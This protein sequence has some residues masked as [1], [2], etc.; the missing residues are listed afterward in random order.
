MSQVPTPPTGGTPGT[1][2]PYDQQQVHSQRITAGVLGIVLS[3]F[4]AH[5]FYLG[6]TKGGIIR[7]ALSCVCVG[8]IISLVEGIMYLTK[9]DEQFYQEYMVNKKGW[10]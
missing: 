9:T 5:R 7:L 8:S 4:G 10:F 2:A 3:G 6:D 1:P